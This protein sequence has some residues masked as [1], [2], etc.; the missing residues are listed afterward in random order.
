MKPYAKVGFIAIVLINTSLAQGRELNLGGGVAL[1]FVNQNVDNKTEGTQIDSNN[2]IV[3]PFLS[4]TYDARY[5]DILAT[6]THNYVRRSLDDADVTNNYTDFNYLGRY[7]IIP[8]LLTIQANGSQ[9]Y[10]SRAANTF[11]VDNFLLNAENLSKNNTNSA[12][13]NLNLPTGRYFG[14]NAQFGINNLSSELDFNEQSNDPS[15]R[16]LST[17]GYNGTVQLNSGTELAPITYNFRASVRGINRA[18]QQDFESQVGNIRLGA[19]LSQSFS[20]RLLGYYENNDIANNQTNVG[21]AEALREF[22]SY[23]VGIAWQSSR[24]R[25]IELG[26]NRSITTGRLG[27]EDEE[28]DFISVDLEWDLSA[29]TRISGNYARRFFGNS[30]NFRFSHSLRNWRSNVSYNERVSSNSQL[31]LNEEEGLLICTNGSTDL[32][33]CSLSD[34]LDVSNLEPNQV[35]VP[36]TIPDFE[37]NDRIIIRKALTAQTA[38]D[39]RRT[40]LTASYTESSNEEVEVSRQIDTSSARLGASLNISPRSSITTSF[41]YSNIERF[42]EGEMEDSVIKQ[43]SIR[44]ERDLT[45]QLSVSIA[46]R[47]LDRSGDNIGNAGGIQGVNGPLT[48]NRISAEISYEFGNKG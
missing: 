29:R 48:D 12:S 23:G 7:Q 32:S 45:R 42:F 14:L 34:G 36:F 47:Y 25:F 4:L 10:R 28:D 3:R 24:S 8:N 22:Y 26:Y 17:D 5:L 1:Q 46:Y 38:L 21:A 33:D 43:A 13:L 35:L 31:L 2:V 18:N 15:Q 19:N 6:A 20:L 11:L 30:G 39:L 9:S 37:L 16:D 41:L 40:T 44:Y 27:E